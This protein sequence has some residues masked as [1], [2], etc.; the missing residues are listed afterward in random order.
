MKFKILFF[1]V[2]LAS[3]RFLTASHK[4]QEL[5]IEEHEQLFNQ[6][7]I[8][9]SN[10][11]WNGKSLCSLAARALLYGIRSGRIDPHASLEYLASINSPIVEL[12]KEE[13]KKIPSLLHDVTTIE[14]LTALVQYK[15]LLGL[16]LSQLNAAKE[17]PIN[18]FI[19]RQRPDLACKLIKLR[20]RV[21]KDEVLK[22]LQL[23]VLGINALKNAIQH[24]YAHLALKIL[25]NCVRDR[26]D[27]SCKIEEVK[28]HLPYLMP[29]FLYK[30]S[31][32][33]VK[34]SAELFPLPAQAA[35]NVLYDAL[36][37]NKDALIGSNLSTINQLYDVH[38]FKR[39]LS[40]F[41]LSLMNGCEVATIN[42]LLDLGVIIYPFE[43]DPKGNTVLH[44]VVSYDNVDLLKR[45]FAMNPL[46]HKVI[47]CCN[48]NGESVLNAAVKTTSLSK[49]PGTNLIGDPTVITLLLQEG[50][51]LTSAGQQEISL[52][53]AAEYNK[54]ELIKIL[55]E[56]GASINQVNEEGETSLIKAMNHQS[57]DAFSVLLHHN[58]NV[59]AGS[60]YRNQIIHYIAHYY[61]GFNI[62]KKEMI[63]KAQQE[64]IN[65]IKVCKNNKKLFTIKAFYLNGPDSENASFKESCID[66]RIIHDI[67]IV[68]ELV[69]A[70]VSIQYQDIELAIERHC[71]HTALWLIGNF[72]NE[73]ALNQ[74]NSK[75]STLLIKAVKKSY[76]SVVE[77]LVA[78][79]ARLDIFDW[80]GKT[81][82][83][84]A[85]QGNNLEMQDYVNFLYGLYH[86]QSAQHKRSFM[87]RPLIYPYNQ[88]V[89]RVK[90]MLCY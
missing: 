83:D 54:P 41:M 76:F 37:N 33:P 7:L 59:S 75:C 14:Q 4:V 38:L 66:W 88:V 1:I 74:K 80:Q 84:Y 36:S 89:E 57:D 20:N 58:A 49:K 50:A 35:H 40:L 11:Q 61:H 24:S 3:M 30:T 29:S 9:I 86:I 28:K 81:A 62:H 42:I 25:K 22:A 2:F 55:I 15:N 71:S 52:F 53:D 46:L 39:K 12:L 64:V 77:E 90:E 85:N 31:T 87:A 45:V 6:P 34:A 68:Q 19:E 21:E 10:Y 82:I 23:N 51:S 16:S 56:Q 8:P 79:G 60:P 18:A 70:G 13:V 44:H 17:T 65:I 43:R 69:E 27:I 26:A 73:S 67:R 72:K 63:Q 5:T 48:Q 78:R 32:F 47:N